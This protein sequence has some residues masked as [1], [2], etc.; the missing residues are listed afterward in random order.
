MA[1]W[2]APFYPIAGYSALMPARLPAAAGTLLLALA[3]PAGAQAVPTIEPLRPC[4]VTAGT[5]DEPQGE[6]VVIRGQG[7]TPNSR[8]NLTVNDAPVPGGD[9]LQVNDTGLL[10]L[11]P[12]PAPWVPN[13]TRDFK[14]TLTE[15]D[16]PA[17]TVTAT[18]MAT[19]LRVNIRPKSAR[20]SQRIR[21]KGS[22]FTADKPVYAH[23]IRKNRQV[24]RVRVARRTGECGS[25]SVRRPQFPMRN[26]QQ[27]TWF[28]QFDQSKKYVDGRSGK[29]ET[30]HV[31]VKFQV[32]LVRG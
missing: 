12:F 21:F 5:Q 30:V 14:V 29:L 1:D 3:V 23:Y 9:G 26:P 25:W 20:P 13:G 27:G 19:K 18:A 31:R 2:R 28:V 11:D 6:G 8:V 15:V 16:N 7:F 22:G 4:Y 24:A 32:S 10:T 17:Q